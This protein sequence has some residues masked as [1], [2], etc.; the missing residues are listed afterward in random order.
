MNVFRRAYIDVVSEFL[1]IA[2]TLRRAD[3]FQELLG[4]AMGGKRVYIPFVG[5]AR[6]NKIYFPNKN[7]NFPRW[8]D[9]EIIKLIYH[10]AR[11][12]GMQVDHIVPLQGKEVCG[13]HVEYNLQLLPAKL[14]AAKR[15]K[16]YDGAHWQLADTGR[17][18]A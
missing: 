7:C 16:L 18:A 2:E 13:L 1:P 8:A 5:R 11:H 17:R 9:Q 10:E 6:S 4:K 3:I 15:N 12:R 14:N